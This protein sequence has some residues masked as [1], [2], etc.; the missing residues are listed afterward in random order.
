MSKIK[1]LF[2]R[3]FLRE[4]GEIFGKMSGKHAIITFQQDIKT[5]EIRNL[6]RECH[7]KIEGILQ[8]SGHVLSERNDSIARQHVNN[9]FGISVCVVTIHLILSLKTR[10]RSASL[11]ARGRQ[12][13]RAFSHVV[14]CFTTH[15]KNKGLLVSE[16]TFDI[17]RNQQKQQ[18]LQILH[19]LHNE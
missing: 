3:K 10:H 8:I 7:R 16:N 15:K 5:W 19:V 4:S 14:S 17:E 13:S 2:H 1:G 11:R 12:F 6:F 18:Q 9:L